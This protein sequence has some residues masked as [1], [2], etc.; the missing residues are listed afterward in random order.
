MAQHDGAA[1]VGAVVSCQAFFSYRHVVPDL[2]VKDLPYFLYI[3]SIR[4]FDYAF[5]GKAAPVSL[6]AGLWLVHILAEDDAV[7]QADGHDVCV[8][9]DYPYIRGVLSLYGSHG[10]VEYV[11]VVHVF[12]R[13]LS[14]FKILAYLLYLIRCHIGDDLELC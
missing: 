9:I 6:A 4:E 11:A 10:N 2:S 7:V 5:Y 3:H 8:M 13:D 14:L 12:Y 1:Y